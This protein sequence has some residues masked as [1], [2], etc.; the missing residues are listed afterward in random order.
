M[1]DFVLHYTKPDGRAP[2]I[3]DNDNGR[4]CMLSGYGTNRVNDHRHVLA[5]AAQLFDRNDFASAAGPQEDALWLLGRVGRAGC[6]HEVPGSKGFPDGGFYVMRKNDDYLLLVAGR[7]G[8]CGRGTHKHNDVF[9]FELCHQGAAFVVDPGC[10]AYT[11]DPE[12]RNQFRSTAYHNTVCIDGE[13]LNR[14]IPGDLFSLR[15]DARP[16]VKKWETTNDHDFFVG[17][18][19]GYVRL[20][21]SLIHE[22]TVRFDK[23]KTSWVIR[24]TFKKGGTSSVGQRSSVHLFEW[25][26][27]LHPN[28][29]VTLD[30][31]GAIRLCHGEVTLDLEVRADRGLE[32]CIRESLYS[33]AYGQVVQTTH[34]RFQ[35]RGEALPDVVFLFR[36]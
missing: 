5:L 36:A 4:L 28:V 13:E 11:G 7:V 8:A 26:F 30:H 2:Q 27:H 21:V 19:S 18:H 33:P 25:N 3:G 24:D 10:P 35:Y 12:L 32:R 34:L 6:N 16:L 22:R 17:Q 31:P 14:F 23:R 9:S 1:C 15:E 20:A 29:E